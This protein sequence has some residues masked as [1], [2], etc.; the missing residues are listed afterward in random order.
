MRRNH[1][2]LLVDYIFNPSESRARFK[3]QGTGETCIV[4]TKISQWEQEDINIE[5]QLGNSNL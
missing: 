2:L 5:L 1:V 3:W 4:G